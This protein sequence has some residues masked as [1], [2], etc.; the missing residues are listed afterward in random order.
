MVLGLIGTLTLIVAGVGI[1]NVMFI[2]V[3]RATRE[4]GI[5]MALGATSYK[6]MAYYGLEALITTAI[7]GIIGLLMAKGVVVIINKIPMKAELL[8]YFGSPRPVLSWTVMI[9]VIAILGAIG[10]LAGFF[11]ARKAA[12]I[13]P[14]EAL[15]YE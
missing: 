6:I 11:P 14:A 12:L 13:N 9:V 10:F 7:G 1:A 2:S 3:K 15:R 4:I 8:Q 5:R